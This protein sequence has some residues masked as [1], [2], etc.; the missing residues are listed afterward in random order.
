MCTVSVDNIQSANL[1][2]V[3]SGSDSMAALSRDYEP[4]E[5]ECALSDL[6]R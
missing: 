4:K 6:I 2:S 1:S 5:L 3:P